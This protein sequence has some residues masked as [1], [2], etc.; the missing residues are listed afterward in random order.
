MAK[1]AENKEQEEGAAQEQPEKLFSKTGLIVLI[2]ANAVWL[3]VFVLFLFL[4]NQPPEE[5]E[6]TQENKSMKT[7]DD[8]NAPKVE[9]QD[10]LVI[11]VAVDEYATDFRMLTID[12]QLQV[13]RL[14]S[15][16]VE[17]F[18]LNN[19]LTQEQFLDTA[20]KLEP[21]IRDIAIDILRRYTYLELQDSTTLL[22][23][24]QRLKNNVNQRLKMYGLPPRIK[25][26]LITKFFI[27]D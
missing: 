3:I 20:Q 7:V 10:P 2:G 12:F 22:E 8:I 27:T 6:E 14:E 15:E 1:E 5:F 13:G 26:V 21:H 11:S 17:G 25:E 24:R 4:A 19:Q 9:M 16:Y 23:F 18:N